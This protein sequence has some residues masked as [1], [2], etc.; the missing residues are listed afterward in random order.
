VEHLEKKS[1][2]VAQV[3]SGSDD[4]SFATQTESPGYPDAGADVPEEDDVVDCVVTKVG[5]G[6]GAVGGKGLGAGTG[7]GAGMPTLHAGPVPMHFSGK[8]SRTSSVSVSKSLC[9]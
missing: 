7:V 8:K 9:A 2:E 1:S 3:P 5:A 4:C 6:K